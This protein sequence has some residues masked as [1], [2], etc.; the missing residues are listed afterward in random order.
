M[1]GFGSGEV[2]AHMRRLE[3]SLCGG[4]PDRQIDRTNTP[5]PTTSQTPNQT[6]NRQNT[7]IQSPIFFLRGNFESK[8]SSQAPSLLIQILLSRYNPKGNIPSQCHLFD[9]EENKTFPNGG[10]KIVRLVAPRKKVER[11]DLGAARLESGQRRVGSV[12]GRFTC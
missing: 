1:V 11:S 7:N 3:R 8:Q 6:N 12:E 2:A 5:C 10:P 4:G 9:G